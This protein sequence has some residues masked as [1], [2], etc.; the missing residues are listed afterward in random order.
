MKKVFS[1]VEIYHIILAEITAVQM[2]EETGVELEWHE[3]IMEEDYEERLDDIGAFD[4]FGLALEK[5]AGANKDLF[6]AFRPISSLLVGRTAEE[7]SI[8]RN[9]LRS[10]IAFLKDYVIEAS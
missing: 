2:K 6:E 7:L 9:V 1:E 10:G 4:S 5:F 8:Q 3:F